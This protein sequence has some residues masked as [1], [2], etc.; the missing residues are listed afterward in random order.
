MVILSRLEQPIIFQASSCETKA[1]WIYEIKRCILE[2]QTN[3]TPQMREILLKGIPSMDK[4]NQ[5][6]DIL[7]STKYES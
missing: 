5:F 7:S 1:T 6:N 3:I 4:A 2:Q